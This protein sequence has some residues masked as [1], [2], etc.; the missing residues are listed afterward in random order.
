MWEEEKDLFVF[1]DTIESIGRKS[2]RDPSEAAKTG[3]TAGKETSGIQVK[4]GTMSVDVISVDRM[5]IV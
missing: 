1:N 5:L 3:K 2:E 4:V